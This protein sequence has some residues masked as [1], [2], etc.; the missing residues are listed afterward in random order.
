MR[1]ILIE[2]KHF[3]KKGKT[4]TRCSA[5]GANLANA[6]NEIRSEF[7]PNEITIEFRETKLPESRMEESDGIWIDGILLEKLLPEAQSGNNDCLSC[8]N[9]IGNSTSCSCRT[10]SQKENIYE[11]IPVKLIKRGMIS[12]LK[13]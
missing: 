5:T 6:I 4:C 3:D 13:S 10:M 12:R 7:N 1:N 2:C 9:L 11:E 8:G